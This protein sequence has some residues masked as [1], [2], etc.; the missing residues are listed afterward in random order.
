MIS[1]D[2]VCL[3]PNCV[4]SS[5]GAK[6]D[7]CSCLGSATFVLVA[8]NEILLASMGPSVGIGSAGLVNVVCSVT[9]VKAVACWRIADPAFDGG[10]ALPVSLFAS[11]DFAEFLPLAPLLV[12]DLDTGV[13]STVSVGSNNRFVGSAGSLTI[14][15][16]GI[17]F[18]GFD[19][20]DCSTTITSS[21]KVAAFFGLPRFFT[22]SLD[23]IGSSGGS[24]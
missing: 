22:V 15:F 23:M 24:N 19:L 4:S 2:D 11:V 17:A 12:C 13:S 16:F 3:A 7:V 18:L 1:P 14:C 9:F 8:L 5:L 21:S 10:F 20:D 6:G